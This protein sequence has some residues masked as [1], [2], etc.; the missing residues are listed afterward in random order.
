MLRGKLLLLNTEPG[1]GA[2]ANRTSTAAMGAQSAGAA[3][4][5][6]RLGV[7]MVLPVTQRVAGSLVFEP[8]V[9]PGDR[10]APRSGRPAAQVR[11]MVVVR[12]GHRR[13]VPPTASPKGASALGP[14]TRWLRTRR[15]ARSIRPAAQPQPPMGLPTACHEAG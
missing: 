7:L 5:R 1:R 4:W 3:R 14:R 12:L 2:V 9:P 8:G 6:L 13:G 10:A 11:L 15:P